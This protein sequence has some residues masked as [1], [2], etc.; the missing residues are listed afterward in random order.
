MKSFF[1]IKERKKYSHTIKFSIYRVVKNKPV[2]IY[3]LKEDGRGYRGDYDSVCYALLDNKHITAGELS[4]HLK[5]HGE[6]AFNLYQVE[7]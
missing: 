4:R 1:Y 3:N 7:Y 6:T 5:G 2:L